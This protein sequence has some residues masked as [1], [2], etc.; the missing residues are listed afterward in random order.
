MT[1]TV[2][3]IVLHTAP[4]RPGREP[5]PAR[6][7]IVTAVTGDTVSLEAFGYGFPTVFHDV[8][9]SATPAPGCWSPLPTA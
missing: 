7:G 4:D 9:F 6:P 5:L 1:P 2:G 8:T 3:Q